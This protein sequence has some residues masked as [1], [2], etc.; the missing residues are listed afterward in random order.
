M[1]ANQAIDFLE[2]NIK[3]TESEEASSVTAELEAIVDEQN[4][5]APDP[6]V[7][8][9]DRG[10]L[11][12]TADWF[13]GGQRDST[14]PTIA[15]MALGNT[16]QKLALDGRQA[17]QLAA[18]ISTT[19]SDDRLRKGIKKILPDANFTNDEYGN[20]VVISPVTGKGTPKDSQY[21]RFYPNP[22]GLDKT[23]LFPLTA[24]AGGGAVLALRW[25]LMGILLV[26]LGSALLGM[27]K[28][29]WLS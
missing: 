22:K 17:T 1:D 24:A 14:I 26:I 12:R 6:K 10:F 27:V 25:A 2:N 28:A 7:K 9:D 29:V 15:E 18:L 19:V 5:L 4:F 3:Q 8:E 23:D 21:V 16:A 13:K 11:K 20:L